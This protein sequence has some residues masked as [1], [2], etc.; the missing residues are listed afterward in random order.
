MSR[1]R[2]SRRQ[3]SATRQ[4]ARGQARAARRA[5]PRRAITPARR[6]PT[7]RRSPRRRRACGRS[8]PRP[9]A[10]LLEVGG[11]PPLALARAGIC[12]ARGDHRLAAGVGRQRQRDLRPAPGGVRAARRGQRARRRRRRRSRLAGCRRRR[13][14]ALRALA[15]A[16]AEGLD[17]D[18]LAA[19]DGRGA[20]DA[21]VAVKGVGPWTADHLPA[22]L[23]RPS[24]RF[25]AGDLALQE[26][27]RLALGLKRGPT[28][29][30]WSRSPSAG[31][32]CAASRRGMLWAYYRGGRSARR[33]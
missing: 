10:R 16:T 15:E 26:A 12:G 19:L 8:I 29:A 28:R 13:S 1:G 14:R 27:A 5:P 31:G 25:P 2:A 21:L 23:P 33:G 4:A 20:H 30:S 32:R 6:S 9:S 11:P 7:R 18:G 17:L 22:V 24:R 3:R